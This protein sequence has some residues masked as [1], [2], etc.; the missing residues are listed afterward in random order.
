MLQS[1]WLNLM[2][3]NL[4]PKAPEAFQSDTNL[5]L[6]PAYPSPALCKGPA[7]PNWPDPLAFRLEVEPCSLLLTAFPYSELD[8]EESR[9]QP[10]GNFICCSFECDAHAR[11]PG[12]INSALLL[13]PSTSMKARIPPGASN[14]DGKD[15]RALGVQD[16]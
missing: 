12:D 2:Y 9:L 13:Y 8:S 14:Q 16:D 5:Q 1:C 7:Q 4:N 3:L 15:T 11:K 6:H 10:A